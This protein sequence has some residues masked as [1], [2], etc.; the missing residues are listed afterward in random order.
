MKRDKNIL[1]SLRRSHTNWIGN[2]KSYGTKFR[3]F[4]ALIYSA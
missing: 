1:E 3:N 4:Y 2:L